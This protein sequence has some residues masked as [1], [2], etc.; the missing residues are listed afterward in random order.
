LTNFALDFLEKHT[1]KQPFFLFLFF[2]EP[3]Q[4]NDLERFVAPK[5]S[6][7]KFKNFEVPDDLKALE[8][9]W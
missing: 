7:E 2:I 1:Q 6:Q 5:N 3:H 9:D 8:G 4:Q